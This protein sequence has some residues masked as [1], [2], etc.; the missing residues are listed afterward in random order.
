M[1]DG[2]VLNYIIK[3]EVEL[4]MMKTDSKPQNRL[5]IPIWILCFLSLILV[6]IVETEKF[7]PLDSP[8][9]G[10]DASYHYLRVDALAERI[11]SG[12]ILSGGIDYL[13]LDGLGYASSLA[14]PDVMLYI[15]AFMRAAGCGIGESMAIF[16][17]VC[18]T[19]F[20]ISSFW[21]TYRISKSPVCAAVA[22]VIFST[23]FYRSDNLY[24]RFALGEVQAFIFWPLIIYGLYDFIFEDFKKPYVLGLGIV[25]MLF[26]HTISTALAVIMC[27]FICLI[28]IKRIIKSP[29]NILKLAVTAVCVLA[30]T[31]F[32][33]IPLLELMSSCELTVKHPIDKASKYTVEFMTLFKD[34]S[35]G[36]GN[37]GLGILIFAVC[38]IRVFVKPQG[39][40]AD[41]SQ[42]VLRKRELLKFADVCLIL[43]FVFV[44]MTVKTPAWKLLAP[45][46]D[47]MQFPWRMFAV[48]TLLISIAVA[49]Y[50]HLIATT[51]R[52]KMLLPLVA[53]S[54]FILNVAVHM[55]NVGAASHVL[56]PYNDDYFTGNPQATYSIGYG[57]W[58]PWSAKNSM[59]TLKQN[60]RKVT[61]NDGTEL[62]Y[63]KKSDYLVFSPDKAYEYVVV[64]YIWYKGYAAYD[65][66]GNE[67][68]TS[69][70][71]IGF[72]KVEL[73]GREADGD[74]RVEYRFTPL[75]KVS[76]AISIVTS[77]LVL[78]YFVT[79]RIRKNK[80]TDDKMKENNIEN[81]ED[82]KE[83]NISVEIHQA[84]EI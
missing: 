71:D 17:M 59:D 66:G 32:Y 30:V 16:L 40:K 82:T 33:W 19:L 14:Y 21:C 79:A 74:I 3:T 65:E 8:M 48:V 75:R 83:E 46:L 20:L 28:Y 18:N 61:S 9:L 2:F 60:T 39:K 44:F 70:S 56:L 11:K 76:V 84:E 45:L 31:S 80:K 64:P 37:A 12:N 4:T 63:E 38:G 27:V 13:F 34:V 24:T 77:V 5:N 10:H 49:I 15:P 23:S 36:Y 81:S 62:K 57:E 25:G 29:K 73:N 53:S 42:D 43:A 6:F 55:H 7:F 78:A 51:F 69:I 41:T 58:L 72:V 50:A 54:V 35:I 1:P 26:T 22:T 47:F 67:Y 68:T 52:S